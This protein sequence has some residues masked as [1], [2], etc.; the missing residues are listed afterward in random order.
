MGTKTRKVDTIDWPAMP[1]MN[2]WMCPRLLKRG[3]S[4]DQP[5]RFIW[6]GPPHTCRLLLVSRFDGAGKG[7]ASRYSRL[8]NVAT[9]FQQ[10]LFHHRT[11]RC[12]TT[13]SLDCWNPNFCEPLSHF[14]CHGLYTKAVSG[15]GPKK[16]CAK[17]FQLSLEQIQRGQQ[18]I[19]GGG[20]PAMERTMGR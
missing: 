17:D 19:A 7:T 2:E 13:I 6:H 9:A 1:W 18:D 5:R 10:A 3:I 11:L 20:T 14:C 12:G 15:G 8:S 16:A 4:I